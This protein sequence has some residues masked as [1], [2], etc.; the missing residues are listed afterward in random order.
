MARNWKRNNG[1]EVVIKKMRDE[2]AIYWR[3]ETIERK[4]GKAKGEVTDKN[5]DKKK[6]YFKIRLFLLKLFTHKL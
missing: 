1:T 6:S 3:E 2:R 4:D 5:A